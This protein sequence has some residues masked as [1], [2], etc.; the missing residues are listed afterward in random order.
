MTNFALFGFFSPRVAHRYAEPPLHLV[1]VEIAQTP[2]E[3][4]VHALLVAHV[5]H[6]AIVAKFLGELHHKGALAARARPADEPTGVVG[7]ITKGGAPFLA[8]RQ[9]HPFL[10]LDVTN[11]VCTLAHPCVI[12]SFSISVYTRR[13]P[14][15]LRLTM[16]AMSAP[17]G[18][19]TLATIFAWP[20]RNCSRSR[21]SSGVTFE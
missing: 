8:P 3:A 21:P 13:R 9:R 2:L 16:A 5:Q 7:W 19:F 15:L 10:R 14:P 4:L 20:F 17:S 1:H 6:P 11:A 12:F 18:A